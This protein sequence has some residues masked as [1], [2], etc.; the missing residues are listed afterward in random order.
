MEFLRLIVAAV[1]ITA[2]I[3]CRN[4]PQISESNNLLPSDSTS[5]RTEL[6]FE[7][8]K[9]I[10]GAINHN[11]TDY[12]VQNGTTKGFHHDILK[13]YANSRGHEIELN[14]INEDY[15]TITELLINDM[16][17][18]V[19]MNVSPNQYTIREYSI[20]TLLFITIL[21]L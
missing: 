21:L 7:P 10:R 3:G 14:I 13:H 16:C 9:Y 15:D 19:A 20:R 12:Y 6:K 5:L 4:N 11:T 18:I 2:S 1:L 8:I 17:D